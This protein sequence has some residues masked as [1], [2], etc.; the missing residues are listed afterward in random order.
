MPNKYQ[1]GDVVSGSNLAENFKGQT[2]TAVGFARGSDVPLC[3]LRS[4]E[5]SSPTHIADIDGEAMDF[6]VASP[7]D[8]ISVPAAASICGDS[9]PEARAKFGACAAGHCVACLPR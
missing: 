1:I 4:H 3:I 7:S 6:L 9:F 5:S 8:T 2:L